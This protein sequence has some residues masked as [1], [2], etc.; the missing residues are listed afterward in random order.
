MFVNKTTLV[1]SSLHVWALGSLFPIFVDF[2]NFLAQ[3]LEKY[4]IFQLNMSRFYV[5]FSNFELI[6]ES[7]PTSFRDQKP[8]LIH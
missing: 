4:G 2:Y 3:I 6:K 1:K 8:V 7:E 5:D